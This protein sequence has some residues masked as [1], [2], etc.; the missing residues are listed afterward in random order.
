MKCLKNANQ[1]NSFR[2]RPCLEISIHALV[3]W[4]FI[5]F[6]NLWRKKNKYNRTFGMT[7]MKSVQQTNSILR[8]KTTT[9]STQKRGR[10]CL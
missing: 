5:A 8:N 4:I 9:L 2:T 1:I 3:N 6:F 7:D 10:V